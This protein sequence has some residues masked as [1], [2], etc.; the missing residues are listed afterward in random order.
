MAN[1]YSV[2]IHQFISEQIADAESGKQK[3][4]VDNNVASRS[5]FE[6]RLHELSKIREYMATH[7]DL[8]TQRYY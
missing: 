3:A 5:Y 8:K 4:E 2:E 1:E 6:G 7:V